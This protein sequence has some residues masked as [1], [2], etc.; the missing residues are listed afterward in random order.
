MKT[1]P[2]G[3]LEELIFCLRWLKGV[4]IYPLRAPV[5]CVASL[6]NLRREMCVVLMVERK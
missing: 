3:L 1:R 5:L 4:E 2:K 6:G